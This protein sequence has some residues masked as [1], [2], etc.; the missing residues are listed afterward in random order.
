MRRRRTPNLGA[1]LT[2]GDPVGQGAV[3]AATSVGVATTIEV[4]IMGPV[5]TRVVQ[6]RVVVARPGSMSGGM[7]PSRAP[8]NMAIR[9]ENQIVASNP[10]VDV[11][12][13]GQRLAVTFRP[14]EPG[15][16]PVFLMSEL[17]A[18]DDDPP[19]VSHGVGELGQIVVRWRSNHQTYRA[20]A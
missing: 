2:T 20:Y 14:T 6:A 5:G 7:D 10:I 8:A 19:R 9:P 4:E 13:N 15:T 11:I 12:P 1:T 18:D 17:T 3:I 16:Y